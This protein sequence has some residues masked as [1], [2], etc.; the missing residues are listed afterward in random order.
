[1]GYIEEL[2]LGK[3]QLA[4]LIPHLDAEISRLQRARDLLASIP[5]SA[6]TYETSKDHQAALEQSSV[7]RLLFNPPLENKALVPGAAEIVAPAAVQVLSLGKSR[8]SQRERRSEPREGEH[9][10]GRRRLVIDTALRGSVPSGPI[11]VSA[12]EVRRSQE[13]KTA[14][15]TRAAELKRAGAELVSHFGWR[16]RAND[17][18]SV[19]ALLQRLINIGDEDADRASASHVPNQVPVLGQS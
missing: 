6:H 9:R 14:Q 7:S 5:I 12:E 8:Q 16:S 17:V 11:V 19:D 4:H 2:Q 18:R 10:A 3:M 1:M 15:A 13:S